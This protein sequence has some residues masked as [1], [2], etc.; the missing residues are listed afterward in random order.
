[1]SDAGQDST[2]KPIDLA[3]TPDFSLGALTVRPA[4]RLV[5]GAGL[6]RELQPR[7]MQVLVAL[8]EGRPRVVSRD[9]LIE[10][11][12]G[13]RIV[14]D[15]ALNRCILALRGLVRDCAP[16]CFVIETVPRVGHRL[17]E[18]DAAAPPAPSPATPSPP[19]R[20]RR[21]LA[22]AIAAVLM[23]VALM[24]ALLWWQQRATHA[25]ATIA[26]LPFRNL[27][28]GDPFFAEGI[29]EEVLNRLAEEPDFQVAG[30]TSAAQ[31]RKAADLREVGRAL[32]VAYVMEGSVRSEPG[33]VRVSASLVKTADGMRI[34]SQTYDRKLDDIFEIQQTI[35]AAVA[36]ALSRK[37]LA[38]AERP[39][40]VASN[41]E[42][43]RDYLSA[44]GMLRM[45][46][47]QLGQ[48]AIALLRQS[49]SAD[50]GFAPA[51]A[52]LAEAIRLNAAL[53]GHERVIAILPE[54]VADARRAIAL[55]PDLAEAHGVL[56]MLLGYGSAEAQA[57]L[58]RAAALDPDDA[59]AQLWL[60]SARRVAGDYE[61]EM[62]AYRH[63]AALDPQWFRPSRDLAVALAEMGNRPAADAIARRTMTENGN[64]GSLTAR[65]AWLYGDFATATRIWSRL[66][67]AESIWQAP[68]RIWLSNA[69]FT[70]R[71]AG[72]GPPIGFAPV[73][74]PRSNGGRFWMAAA[75][76]PGIW[77]QRNRDATAALVYDEENV[78]AAKLML[79]AG[80]GRELVQ[81]YD[82]PVGLLGLRRGAAVAAN[83]LHAAP[84]V[85][86][87]LR[88]AGRAGE[89]DRLLAGARAR[90][91]AVLRRGRVPFTVDADDAAIAA[92]AGQVDRAVT[93]LERAQGRGWS[94]CAPDDLVRLA[95]E[96]AFA[97]IA[98]DPRFRAVVARLDA[99]L[100]RER[101]KALRL[102]L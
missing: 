48:S 91:D 33:R 25:P 19:T 35:G 67:K 101:E 89:A 20:H 1:M 97:T 23:I 65:I 28:G 98:A 70:M 96:P 37:L 31:Y 56:G 53:E 13:G 75:P 2:G 38:R 54:A 99:A 27:S 79:T 102:K 71:L 43:Y 47:P 51:W 3:R 9:Q 29:G 62:A 60:A 81:G 17:I 6:R 63:A 5:E 11:C 39:G 64:K 95:E 40:T 78:V 92:A 4:E 46:N 80:R 74:E 7:V 94:H 50:P 90:M 68:N 72:A 84:L 66:V 87:A 73:A 82:G 77:R 24:G 100:A 61:G 88:Q 10:R 21:T 26:V 55:A 69:R 12:W 59:Q 93:A 18:R 15:D 57:H 30:R 14:G 49:V 22:L 85:A 86:L 83:D 42:A 76:T 58:R 52:S 16:E 32:D 36:D 44:R 34:W 8:A 45:R 41:G